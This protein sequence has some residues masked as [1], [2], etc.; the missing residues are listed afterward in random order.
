MNPKLSDSNKNMVISPR[1]VL[2]SKT[3]GQL[4]A[5]RNT[6]LRLRH[7]FTVTEVSSF[8]VPPPHLRAEIDPVSE[9]LCFLVFRISSISEWFLSPSCILH[10]L[11]REMVVVPRG[12]IVETLSH[13]KPGQYKRDIILDGQRSI[14]PRGHLI[15]SSSCI[16]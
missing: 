2:H 14:S 16:Y 15:T 5:G 7:G 4:T 1:W 11:E 12:L 10:V 3:N 9:T 13:P 6:R 8:Y